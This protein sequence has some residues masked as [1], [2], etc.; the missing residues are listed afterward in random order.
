[1]TLI[2]VH[3][4]DLMSMT[5]NVELAICGF[6]NAICNCEYD[7]FIMVTRMF[8]IECIILEIGVLKM[9]NSK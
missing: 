7:I 9:S 8:D 6:E 4:L 5:C 3:G 1:M 2:P